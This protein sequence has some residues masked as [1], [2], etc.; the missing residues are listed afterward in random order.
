MN[1][2]GP[3]DDPG[4]FGDIQ[5]FGMVTLVSVTLFCCCVFSRWSHNNENENKG[6]FAL[7]NRGGG[8]ETVETFFLLWMWHHA[9]HPTTDHCGKL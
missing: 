5:Y 7:K 4:P 9:G 2:Q 8:G 1:N 3:K 6:K